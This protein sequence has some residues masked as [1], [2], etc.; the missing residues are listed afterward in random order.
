MSVVNVDK[1]PL[2]PPYSIPPRAPHQCPKL[3]VLPPP[4]T[5][6]HISFS[7]TSLS[8]RSTMSFDF[9]LS[10]SPGRPPRADSHVPLPPLLCPFLSLILSPASSRQPRVA[11][12]PKVLTYPYPS[13]RPDLS[14]PL[15]ID[16]TTST[17]PASFLLLLSS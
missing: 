7:V 16:P 3:R 5:H 10:L 11:V 4:H 6:T 9:S 15:S 12:A 13:S 1:R 14:S 2:S 8:F 17:L